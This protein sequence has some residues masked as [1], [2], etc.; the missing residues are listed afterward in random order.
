MDK[1]VVLGAEYDSDLRDALREILMQMGG[2][3]QGADWAMGGSQELDSL[4]VLLGERTIVVES[5]T[6]VGLSV[7]GPEELVD[8]IAEQLGKSV[9]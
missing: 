2:E 7:T 3:V 9:Y 4:K 8:R 1:T 5:E 6:Y